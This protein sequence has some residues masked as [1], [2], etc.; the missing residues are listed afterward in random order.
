ME[1]NF[2]VLKEQS[3]YCDLLDTVISQ[4]KKIERRIMQEYDV[5]M[6]YVEEFRG[7]V[8]SKISKLQKAQQRR[9]TY[10]WKRG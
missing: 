1:N 8:I 4:Q 10:F 2:E 5:F 7:Q 9:N 3:Q 6:Q